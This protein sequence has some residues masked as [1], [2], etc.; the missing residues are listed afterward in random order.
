M[1]TNHA[2]GRKV[3]PY[4]LAMRE[5]GA[6]SANWKAL[7]VQASEARA[8][9]IQAVLKASEAGVSEYTLAK[10]AG[11]TRQTVRGWLGK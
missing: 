3:P 9:L 2:T 8:D 10:E 7:Q 11:V 4:Q 1:T 6:L 5:V